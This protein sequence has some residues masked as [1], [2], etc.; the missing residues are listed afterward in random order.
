VTP[1]L[2]DPP[3]PATP[4]QVKQSN[5]VPFF[6]PVITKKIDS[7]LFK[8]LLHNA[9]QTMPET[10]T[11]ATTTQATIGDYDFENNDDSFYDLIDFGI[12]SNRGRLS[13]KGA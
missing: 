2:D 13:I 4:Q 6:K 7:M 10:T 3:H 12:S 9:T 1:A 8:C 11:Q 5:M